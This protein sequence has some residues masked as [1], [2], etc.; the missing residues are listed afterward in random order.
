MLLANVPFAAAAPKKILFFSKSSGF[1]HPV[2]SWKKGRPS[3]VETVLLDI[4]KRQGWEFTFSKDG[5]LFSAEYLK[6]FDGVMFYTSGDLCKPGT[7]KEPPMTPEGKQ[8]LLDWVRGGGSFIGTHAASD[9]FRGKGTDGKPDPYT[10]LLGAEFLGHGPQQMATN[11]VPDPAFPGFE[12]VGTSYSLHEEWY[13]MIHFNPEM[14]V[15]SVLDCAHLNGHVYQR[16]PYPTTWARMEGTGKVF[17]TAMGHRDDIW[18]N[19]LF[20]KILIGGIRWTLGE[21][22]ADVKTNFM[23]TVPGATVNPPPAPPKTPTPVATPK[24]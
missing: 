15:L 8:A 5:S 23:E 9:T 2:I 22:S 20:Q 3:H 18:T 21:A 10:Q 24:A 6:Q 17:Y 13:S 4:G 14:R 12:E 7:D 1:E 19:P 16:P 11:S